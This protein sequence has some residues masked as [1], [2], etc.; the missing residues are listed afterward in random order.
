MKIS[1]LSTALMDNRIFGIDI[2]TIVDTCITLIAI[3]VLF[4]LLSYLLFEPARKLIK[5]R[6]EYIQGQLDE[7]AKVGE[8]ADMRK[9]EYEKKISGIKE[10]ADRM[11][12]ESRRKA[13]KREKEIVGEA[14]DEAARIRARAEKEIELEQSRAKDEVKEQIVEVAT[15]M[16]GKFIDG[17]LDEEKQAAMID[18]T[19]EKLG[20]ETWAN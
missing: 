4:L 1:L 10:E 12:E 9:E 11:L 17:S 3:F 13:Q 14:N 19:L 6:Q 15:L 16:A 7:A 8:E 5:Q 18:E 2:Q 20:D